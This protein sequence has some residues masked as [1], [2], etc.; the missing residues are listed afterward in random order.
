LLGIDGDA[1]YESQ[2]RNYF[3]AS[4]ASHLPNRSR[5]ILGDDFDLA[6]RAMG[7]G[8]DREPEGA[9]GLVR[10][11]GASA[12]RA[13]Q[14]IRNDLL[15]AGALGPRSILDSHGLDAGLADRV[16]GVKD[17]GRGFGCWKTMERHD[18]Q[19]FSGCGQ[20]GKQAD[21]GSAI[22]NRLSRLAET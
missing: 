6:V 11:R 21:R 3:A 17:D 4:V 14:D 10:S 19:S 9:R 18:R 5:T 16:Q 8:S 20:R 12:V 13:A 22:R 7:F 15:L 1:S 2:G